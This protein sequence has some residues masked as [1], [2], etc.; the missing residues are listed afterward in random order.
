MLPSVAGLA[1]Y[2]GALKNYGAVVDATT[3]RPDAGA[4]PAYADVAAMTHT[5]LR[6]WCQFTLLASGGTPVLVAHDE[7]WNNGNNNAPVVA[8]VGAGSATITYPATVFDE[9]PAN[10]PGAN[11]GGYAVNLRDCWVSVNRGSTWVDCKAVIIA[12]NQIQIIFWNFTAGAPANADPTVDT[13]IR[14][15]GI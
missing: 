13:L 7:V 1:T 12:P 11:P 14:V 9:I 6:V 8:R 4:N 10:Q 2:G 3:D 5:A 15:F